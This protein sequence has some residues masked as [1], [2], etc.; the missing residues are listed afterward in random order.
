MGRRVLLIADDEEMNR[1]VIRKF[2]KS[3]YDVL[4]AEDGI[5]ALEVLRSHHVDAVLLDIIMPGMDGL[6]V[7]ELM[8]A[9]PKLAKIGVLVATSMKEKTER[10][11]LSLGAD[12]VI[13]KP[14]DPIVIK[15]RLENIR[16][17]KIMEQQN[18]LLQAANIELLRQKGTEHYKG[19]LADAA[20]KLQK[21]AEI[22]EENMENQGLV[23]EAVYEITRQAER[24]SG[25]VSQ[26][27]EE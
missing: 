4:E 13:A 17:M 11:A 26:N 1:V 25:I 23:L 21:L 14:Y 20:Q 16:A 8:K 15:K 12:D 9:D 19:E 3:N 2:L 6:Q 7:L 27:S 18:E 10:T 5:K 22:I 24:I